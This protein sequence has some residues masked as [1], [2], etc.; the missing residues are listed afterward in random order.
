MKKIS[1]TV[2]I[3]VPR[4]GRMRGVAEWVRSS[5]VRK[6]K[7]R[8]GRPRFCQ[9]ELRTR[10]GRRQSRNFSRSNGGTF[11]A[12]KR[13]FQDEEKRKYSLVRSIS[14]SWKRRFRRYVP[15]PVSSRRKGRRSNPSRIGR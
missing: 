7:S 3:F 5:P 15:T 12:G 13:S 9:S 1:W 14:A 11:S 10:T 4:V 2:T 8:E 6:K